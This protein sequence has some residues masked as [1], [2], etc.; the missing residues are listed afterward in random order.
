MAKKNKSFHRFNQQIDQEPTDV[1]TAV[2]VDTP[3]LETPVFKPEIH[4][5]TASEIEIIKP[6]TSSLKELFGELSDLL[7]K[8]KQPLVEEPINTNPYPN[9]PLPSE[10]NA[11]A[12][13]P[14][15]PLPV[16]AD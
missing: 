10:R 7:A 1:S 8:D 11:S 15:P 14:T 13:D 4:L 12:A 3:K 6:D 16:P 2:A 9:G 5:E